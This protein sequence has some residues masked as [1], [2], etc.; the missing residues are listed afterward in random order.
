MTVMTAIFIVIAT[1]LTK[2]NFMRVTQRQEDK[3]RQEKTNTRRD[4][5][6]CVVERGFVGV[7]QGENTRQVAAGGRAAQAARL[8]HLVLLHLLLLLLRLQLL[9]IH[10]RFTS[11][12]TAS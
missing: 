1:C 8:L 3:T 11:M 5:T 7:E 6:T 12:T 9:C 10:A 4:I 2:L